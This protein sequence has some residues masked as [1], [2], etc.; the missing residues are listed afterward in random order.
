LT[1]I[2]ESGRYRLKRESA[3]DGLFELPEEAVV[4]NY[5]TGNV[6]GDKTI[7]YLEP[8]EEDSKSKIASK[9]DTT[10]DS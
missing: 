8:V 1:R 6:N 2:Q 9:E 10:G 3:E 4:L 5:A 7:V